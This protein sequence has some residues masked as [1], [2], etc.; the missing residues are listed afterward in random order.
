MPAVLKNF[1]DLGYDDGGYAYSDFLNARNRLYYAADHIASQNWSD[2]KDELY[3]AADYFGSAASD[4]L[5][6]NIWGEGL[7]GHWK[8]AFYWINDNWPSDGDDYTLTMSKMLTAM[9]ESYDWEVLLFITRIDA[10]RG[11]ISEKTV[12]DQAMADQ[13]R[14]FLE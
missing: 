12:T 3:L 11:S 13:L 6:D 14:H 4:L 8:D 10:M 7:R 1:I 9:W 2:A 5:R